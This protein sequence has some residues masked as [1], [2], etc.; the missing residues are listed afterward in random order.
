M[1]TMKSSE[2]KKMMCEKHCLNYKDCLEK[3]T[4]WWYYRWTEP[5]DNPLISHDGDIMRWLTDEVESL[6][7]G[8]DYIWEGDSHIDIG[9]QS[10][11]KYILRKHALKNIMKNSDMLI[12]DSDCW[13]EYLDIEENDEDRYIEIENNSEI[14]FKE[15]IC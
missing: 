4:N 10:K 1:N 15:S 9:E 13:L 12:Q 3:M 5:C 14:V 6:K 2:F 7:L 11:F 8:R